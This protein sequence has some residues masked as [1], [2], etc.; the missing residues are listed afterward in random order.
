M[1]EEY[2]ADFETLAEAIVGGAKAYLGIA[3]GMPEPEWGFL[4]VDLD[5]GRTYD[6]LDADEIHVVKAFC[7]TADGIPVMGVEN[8]NDGFNVFPISAQYIEEE[9]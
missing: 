4:L 8:T 3:E 5:E 6:A 7:V 1:T 2:Y 9:D